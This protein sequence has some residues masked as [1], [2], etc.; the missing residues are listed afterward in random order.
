MTINPVNSYNNPVTD[1]ENETSIEA[2]CA[3][4]NETVTLK[5]ETEE[6][7]C[8][9]CKKFNYDVEIKE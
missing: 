4:C 2:D 9:Y 1:D 8:P 5:P 3:Q 7:Y 6:F